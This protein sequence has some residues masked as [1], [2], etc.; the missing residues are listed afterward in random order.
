M[1]L[2][3][4]TY[5]HKREATSEYEGLSIVPFPIGNV[6]Y[7]KAAGTLARFVTVLFHLFTDVN[8]SKSRTVAE[9]IAHP[10]FSLFSWMTA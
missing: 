4:H 2:Y 10:Q 8:I 1:K 5:I 9:G 7:Y 6:Y 3:L